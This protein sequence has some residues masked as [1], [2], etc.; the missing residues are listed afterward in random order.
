[1]AP[2]NPG[3]AI[4]WQ[5]RPAYTVNLLRELNSLPRDDAQLVLTLR[6]NTLHRQ[7]AAKRRRLVRDLTAKLFDPSEQGGNDVTTQR[8]SKSHQNS[9][10]GRCLK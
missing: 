5:K 6:L 1:M 7:L 9:V 8:R 2:V 3:H 10:G 4:Q